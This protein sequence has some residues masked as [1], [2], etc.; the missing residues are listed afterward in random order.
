ME[1]VDTFVPSKIVKAGQ[2]LKLP[3]TR[4]K[5]VQRAKSNLRKAKVKARTTGLSGDEHLASDAK[6]KVDDA[7]KE[8]KAHYENKL[9]NDSKEN[10]KRFW[11]YAR[12]YTR[13]SSSIDVLEQDGVKFAG[14]DDKAEILNSF[15][16]SVLTNETPPDSTHRATNVEPEFILRDLYISKDVIRKK[17][18]KLKSNRASGPDNISIN[19]L[20]NVPNL[21]TPLQI[22][23]NQSL[24]TSR[25]P[26]D[27]R[28]ANVTPLFKKG[29]RSRANN[30]RPVS[31]TSQVV[32]VLERIIYDEL[33]SLAI[34]NK[35]ISCDQHGFQS[36]CS[37]VTHCSSALVIGQQT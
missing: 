36:Q 27:W 29:S 33:L 31:L 14:D 17:L 26:Q 8:A 5:S 37:C 30:Y 4:Y 34:K 6:I 7:I 25:V 13:S 15:F 1:A 24:A 22:I 28:D 16:S 23:Y 35:T 18:S 2:R 11:N 19:V 3:W 20:R 12:H 9:I 32:K 21:D 10:P